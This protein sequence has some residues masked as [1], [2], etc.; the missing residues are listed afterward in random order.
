MRGDEVAAVTGLYRLAAPMVALEEH[1]GR[2]KEKRY[3][4]RKIRRLLFNEFNILY[5]HELSIPC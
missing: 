2:R 3:Q 5:F 1:A 4:V